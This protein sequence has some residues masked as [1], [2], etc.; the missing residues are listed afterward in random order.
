MTNRTC[1]MPG[2]T[3]PLRARGMCVT[4]YNQQQPDRHRK[5]EI[6]CGYCG[7]A[8]SKHVSS[9][10]AER[11]CS[12]LC[13]DVWRLD[14]PDSRTRAKADRLLPVLAETRWLPLPERHPARQQ[15]RTPRVWTAGSCGWCA[16]PFIS[17]QPQT[18]YCSSAC[19]K[20]ISSHRRRKRLGQQRLDLTQAQRLT[21]YVRDQWVCQLC[22]EAVDPT[23][24]VTSPNDDWAPSLDHIVTRSSGGSDDADNLRLAHRWCN[25]I[26]GDETY[27][28][29]SVFR[30]A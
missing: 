11:F 23:L 16:H 8:T 18:R 5:V 14:N 7:Q 29:E 25:S 28:A 6:A 10:Y 27:Y 9:K 4:H 3:K 2:C 12:L 20:A 21:L 1:S 24:M 15:Q 19:A 26:R 22:D 17:S 13:R 30:V